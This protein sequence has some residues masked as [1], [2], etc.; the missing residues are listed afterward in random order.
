[1][2]AIPFKEQNVVYAENQDEYQSLP[3]FSDTE[4]GTVTSCW[5]LTDEEFKILKKTKKLYIRS[6]T[7]NQPL[8]PLFASAKRSD[9]F[10]RLGFTT[11]QKYIFHQHS[12][13]PD[14]KSVV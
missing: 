2:K 6:L 11:G 9:I 14:R 13:L 8:Q 10:C 7:F 5:E 1:M 4:N 3:A 12:L